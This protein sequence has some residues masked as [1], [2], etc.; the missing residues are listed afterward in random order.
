MHHVV[1]H[2]NDAGM[3]EVGHRRCA[4]YVSNL[5]RNRGGGKSFIRASRFLPV[6][7]R[8]DRFTLTFFRKPHETLFPVGHRSACMHHKMSSVYGEYLEENEAPIHT[9]FT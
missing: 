6:S 7:H 4:V 1:T 8:I 9:H 2:E 5:K 3:R